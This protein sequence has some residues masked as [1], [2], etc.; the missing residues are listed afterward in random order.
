M[1]AGVGTAILVGLLVHGFT[2]DSC[3][4]QRDQPFDACVDSRVSAS[5]LIPPLIA[6]GVGFA[7]TLIAI[8]YA[9][10]PHPIAENDAKALADAY[11]QRLR[12]ELG[13]PVVTRR[14]LLHDVEV[15]PFVARGDAGLTL[16]AR[17]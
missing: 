17:F 14:P 11:N 4:S 10:D 16:G 13:L 12:R 6:F 15:T 7:G 9:S 3:A 2:M 1:T 8:H 5:N